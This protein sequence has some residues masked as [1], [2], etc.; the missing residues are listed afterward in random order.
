MTVRCALALAA[1]SALAAGQ[2][3]AGD[4][5]AAAESTALKVDRQASQADTAVNP[6]ADG[7]LHV[8]IA[9]GTPTQHSYVHVSFASLPKGTTVNSLVLTLTQ[10]GS[11]QGNVEPQNAAIAACPLTTELPAAYDSSNPPKWDC[12]RASSPGQAD[13]SGGW[14]IDLQPLV[15]AWDQGGN[16]GAAIIALA[17]P[18]PVG[19]AAG[20]AANNWALAFDPSRTSATA[21]VTT[22]G[23]TAPSSDSSG[24]VPLTVSPA[25]PAAVA[26][27]LPPLA[28]V[29]PP[30]PV[31]PAPAGAPAGSSA[32]GAAASPSTAPPRTPAVTPP[33]SPAA[34]VSRGWIL[35]AALLALA[36]LAAVAGVGVRQFALRG[37]VSFGALVSSLGSARS[38]L[39]TPV[40][41]LALG[42]VL[43]AGFAG[44][45]TAS[46]AAGP[47]A[48][49]TAGGPQGAD[50]SGSP[51]APGAV[52]GP[53]A[54]PTG[55]AGG[56]A[57]AGAG[58]SGGSAAASVAAASA[59]AA[60]ASSAAARGPLPRGVTPTTVRVG[61]FVATNQ[62]TLNQAAGLNG[63]DNTGDARAQAT[64]MVKWVNAHGGIAGHAI[65]PR[66]IPED[67][68]NT[69]PNYQ[70]Q[71]CHQAVDD[72]QVFAMVDDNNVVQ[73]A[74]QCYISSHTLYFSEG[75]V[76]FA[77]ATQNAWG[78]YFWSPS[79]PNLDRSMA[80]ELDGLQSKGF[81]T[82]ADK[83]GYMYEDQPTTHLTIDRV[84]SPRLAQMGYD[85]TNPNAPNGVVSV[86]I[87]VPI[88]DANSLSAINNGMLKMKTSGVT[89]MF[90]VNDA[91]ATMAVFAMRDADNLRYNTVTY[92]LQSQDGLD[93]VAYLEPPAQL[94][95]AVAVGYMPLLDTSTANS[96]GFPGS[97]AE[98][99]CLKIMSDAGIAA[100]NPPGRDGEA[101][102]GMMQK[103]DAMF[104]LYHGAQNLG[105]SL[106]A[107]TFAAGAERLGT[108]YQSAFGYAGN[109]SVGPGHHDAVDTYRT[110]HWDP[111]CTNGYDGGTGKGSQGCFKLDSRT[112]YRSPEV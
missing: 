12:T 85:V 9:G 112:S 87:T 37:S 48:T 35:A 32:S 71:L 17:E 83:V 26:P 4:V 94:A 53:G 68:S 109:S 51:A 96:D 67:A 1:A 89:K 84:V 104:L 91:G 23:S 108:T 76:Q 36:A 63:L 56:A 86:G 73:T 102:A 95:H 7:D 34:G 82:K 79:G 21:G 69:D 41:V 8:A 14:R 103:C 110:L 101:T 70:V 10:S 47:G 52:G 33:A 57:G 78:I 3:L 22:P 81:F 61:F 6:Y 54:S 105:Q 72:E 42:A 29:A 20:P 2:A 38:R 58:T 100:P 39:A 98:A 50:T 13:G 16:T 55:G 77:A 40:A 27:A 107:S 28:S 5:L 25:A 74:A 93:G 49:A 46:G 90:F 19:S 75:L 64:A 60:A 24:F 62:N 92:G 97:P 111:S 80:E 65:D 45:L 59:A 15:G 43:A 31:P 66:F 88:A 44:R 11:A 30:A 18:L 106:S 99:Q